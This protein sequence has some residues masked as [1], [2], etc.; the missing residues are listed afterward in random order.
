MPIYEYRCRDCEQ[1]VSLFRRISDESTPSCPECGQS[2]LKRCLS[3]VSVVKS[4][5]D[6]A[7]D[8]SWVDKDLARRLRNQTKGKL[9]P[10]FR[11]TLDRME[12]H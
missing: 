2:H 10:Q 4:D 12:S 6:C 5:A 1:F 9:S 7:R 3:K 8:V 11:N